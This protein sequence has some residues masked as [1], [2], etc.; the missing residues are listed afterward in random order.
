M[1]GEEALE[2]AGLRAVPGVV[3]VIGVVVMVIVVVVMVIMGMVVIVGVA[4]PMVVSR[5]ARLA[6]GHALVAGAASAAVIYLVFVQ[7]LELFVFEG[8]VTPLIFG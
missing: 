6:V 5:L 7:M 4:V 3:V 1:L 8:L 2:E